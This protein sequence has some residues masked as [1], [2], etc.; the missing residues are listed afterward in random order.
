VVPAGQGKS[1]IHAALTCLFLEHTDH[2]VH[3]VF[4]HEGLKDAD[5][6]RNEMLAKFCEKAGKKWSSRV[7]YQTDLKRKVNSRKKTVLII[8]E[9]DERMFRDLH[10]F[11]RHTRPENVYTICLTATAYD[12]G[13]DGLERK[14]IDK[15]D[16]KIYANSDRHEQY[17]PVINETRDLG[18]LE[19]WRTFI[20]QERQKCGVLVY[21]TGA[22]YEA[23]KAE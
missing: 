6:E 3:V 18:T 5:E 19:A 9:S 1:R 8:D 20:V 4:Q 11:H 16:F 12:G 21:A 13:A 2:D 7:H 14:A 22:V 10:E 15:L 17:N 23:L